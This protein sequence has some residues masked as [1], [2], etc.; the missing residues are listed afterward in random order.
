MNNIL[1]ELY[2]GEIY[3]SEAIVSTDPEYKEIRTTINHKKDYLQ[4]K[5]SPEDGE[6]L[7]RLGELYTESSAL[8]CYASFSYGFKLAARL[9]HECFTEDVKAPQYT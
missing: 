2:S 9:M 8:M 4:K 1:D 3:P 5:L 7:D 6:L